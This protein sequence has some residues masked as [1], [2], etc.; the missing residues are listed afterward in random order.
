MFCL[1][2][3]KKK[4]HRIDPLFFFSFFSEK[5]LM[6]MANEIEGTKQVKLRRLT[7]TLCGGYQ[8]D[9]ISLKVKF[10]SYF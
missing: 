1:N 3:S 8:G 9:L 5:A 10:Y 4:S 6:L 2:F 7:L